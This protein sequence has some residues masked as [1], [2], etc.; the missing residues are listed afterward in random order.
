MSIESD[1]LHLINLTS[2]QRANS[3]DDITF[4][5]NTHDNVDDDDGHENFFQ[6]DET[7]ET[8]NDHDDI[9]GCSYIT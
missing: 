8:M 1:K 2:F 3:N 9:R 5:R 4:L 6:D 7:D